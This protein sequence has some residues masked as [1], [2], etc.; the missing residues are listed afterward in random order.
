MAG[1]MDHSDQHIA[2]LIPSNS[3]H[4]FFFLPEALDTYLALV[5]APVVYTFFSY[6]PTVASP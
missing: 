5:L 4:L 3:Y 2:W 6:F 1:G